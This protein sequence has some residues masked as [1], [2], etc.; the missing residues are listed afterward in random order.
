M[1]CLCLEHSRLARGPRESS[2]AVAFSDN[3]A[4]HRTS[5]VIV[6]WV[7]RASGLSPEGSVPV[8][9]V[10]GLARVQNTDS[11]GIYEIQGGGLNERVAA[12]HF[13]Q[14]NKD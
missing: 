2:G 13:L 7:S 1:A 6:E 14:M 3:G 4:T 9:V 10:D 12:N 8:Q 11:V 5:G